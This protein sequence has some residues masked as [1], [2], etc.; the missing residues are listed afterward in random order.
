MIRITK[1]TAKVTASV[2]R[3]VITALCLILVIGMAPPASA[4][5]PLGGFDAFN[6]LRLATWRLNDFDNNNDGDIRDDEGLE[7][8]I[9][10]GPSGFTEEEILTVQSALDVWGNVP[11]SFAAFRVE[12]ITRDPLL[13]GVEPDFRNVIA[14]QVTVDEQDE[15]VLVDPADIIVADVAFPVLGLT[16]LLFTVE[17]TV[18]ETAGQGVTVGAGTIIDADIIID[19]G[20]ARPDPVTGTNALANL[21][22]VMVHELGHFLGLGHT[23]LNNL[24]ASSV[25]G[26]GSRLLESPAI[27][28][29]GS[30]GEQQHVGV[31]PTMYP[32]YWEVQTGDDFI[33]GMVDLAPDDI[34]AISYLYPRQNQ[35][36]FF[37]VNQEARSQRR[38]GSGFPST[39]LTGGHV[40]AWADTDNNPNTSYVPVFSTMA[41]LYQPAN[42]PQLGGL[43]EIL[44][45]WKQMEQPGAQGNLFT[46]SY[47]FTVSPL[48]FTG[49]DR[50]S[51]PGILPEDIDSLQGAGGF[52]ATSRAT[53]D[54]TT[55]FPSEVFQEVENLIDVS[56]RDAGTPMVWDFSRNALISVDTGETLPTI[57]PVDLPMFGDPNDVCPLNIIQGGGT[58]AVA[59]LSSGPGVLRG[60]RDNLLLESTVGTALV[61]AYY[62]TGPWIARYLLGNATAFRVWR[63]VVLSGYWCLENYR[64]LAL[65]ACLPLLLFAA[66]RG[67]RRLRRAATTLL[68]LGTLGLAAPAHAAIAFVTDAQLAA[69]AQEAIVVGKVVALESRW[70]RGGRIYTDVSFEIADTAKGRLN[71][72]S[73]ITISVVGGQIGALRVSASEAPNFVVGDEAVLY[74]NFINNAYVIHGGTRGTIRILSDPAGKQVVQTNS[75]YLAGEAG[76]A[77]KAKYLPEGE[78]ATASQEASKDGLD[79]TAEDATSNMQVPLS[80]YMNYLRS[81]VREEAAKAP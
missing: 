37:S 50:Q 53:T 57:L 38:A 6:V 64:M 20:S 68:V 8:L 76:A 65:L 4:F 14:M 63:G 46:P 22:G 41:G 61:S 33:P 48:N 15:N 77:L 47:I 40:V 26:S 16:V 71:K 17:D 10:G 78:D 32:I 62:H 31:T 36:N 24:R 58:G 29:T 44:G 11:T 28:F 2:R 42:S 39:P 81:V 18:L 59:S 51:P 72:S 12:G 75:A 1:G 73:V 13:A 45:M 67:G 19:A 66:W 60:L 43:F 25:S 49:Y 54:Y 7:V 9:E 23:P 27:Y 34:S 52:S 30:D 5:F 70:A 3:A 79:H 21:E 56:N 80:E 74:L 35:S 69:G 55:A